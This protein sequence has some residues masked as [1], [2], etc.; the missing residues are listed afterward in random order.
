M[1]YSV[2]QQT[3]EIG[4][5]LALGAARHDI[6]VMVIAGAMRLAALGLGAGLVLALLLS[7]ALTALLYGTRGTDPATLAGA[8]VVLAGVAM[9]AAYLPA[10]RAARIEP[11][12]ALRDQ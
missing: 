9:L 1:S 6:L 3:A 5:R 10:R 2:G 7:R 4:V 11:V 12:Q 8:V